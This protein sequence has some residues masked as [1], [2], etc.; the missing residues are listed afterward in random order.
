MVVGSDG[1]SPSSG[2]VGGH[3]G[4]AFPHGDI[5]VSDR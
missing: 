2:L 5:D 4:S 3:Y 1:I